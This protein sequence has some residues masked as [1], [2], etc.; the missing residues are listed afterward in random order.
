M[1]DSASARY[2]ARQA[3]ASAQ[4]LADSAASVG[5]SFRTQALSNEPDSARSMSGRLGGHFD[6][7]RSEPHEIELPTESTILGL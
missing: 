1:S 4:N 2:L 3:A 7:L 5:T 6:S